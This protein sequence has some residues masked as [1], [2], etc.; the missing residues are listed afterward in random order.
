MLARRIHR[1]PAEGHPDMGRVNR[2]PKI[3]KP[4]GQVDG[5]TAR[6]H[7]PT[8]RVPKNARSTRP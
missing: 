7:V 6:S 8:A 2:G 4:S 5:S 1:T 3:A